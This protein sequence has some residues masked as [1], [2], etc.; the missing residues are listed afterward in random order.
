MRRSSARSVRV[1]A[2]RSPGSFAIAP[3]AVRRLFRGEAELAVV[4]HVHRARRIALEVGG[5]PRV[6][7]TLGSW[8]EGNRSYLDVRDGV[9]TLYDGPG[10]DRALAVF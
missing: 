5:R 2:A 6:L 10:A 7:V 8:D 9:F 3:C 1:K 4:G